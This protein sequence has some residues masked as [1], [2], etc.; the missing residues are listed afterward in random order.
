MGLH[1]GTEQALLWVPPG[2]NLLLLD[3][4]L[5]LYLEREIPSQLGDFESESLFESSELL[6]LSKA[7]NRWMLQLGD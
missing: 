1:T 6:I 5:N 2:T 7:R 4:K 3:H